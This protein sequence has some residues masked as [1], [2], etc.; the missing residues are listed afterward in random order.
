VLT[1]TT[2]ADETLGHEL[3]FSGE[4]QTF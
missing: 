4:G 3:A 1:G 2:D